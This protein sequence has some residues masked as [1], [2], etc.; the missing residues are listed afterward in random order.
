MYYHHNL[1]TSPSLIF[2]VHGGDETLRR[3]EIPIQD[4]TLNQE[5]ILTQNET[6][7]QVETWSQHL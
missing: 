1:W 5:E 7:S 2:R 6:L 3:E 4:E